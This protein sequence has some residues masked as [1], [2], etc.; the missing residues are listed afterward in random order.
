[1]RLWSRRVLQKE[2]ENVGFAE[3]RGQTLRRSDGAWDA[4]N[5]RV[6]CQHF[7]VSSFNISHDDASAQTAQN[8]LWKRTLWTPESN[9]PVIL[10]SEPSDAQDFSSLCINVIIFEV[11]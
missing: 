3:S 9:D 7:T 2:Q 10:K 1:M 5:T 4:I 6:T 11:I 8:Q